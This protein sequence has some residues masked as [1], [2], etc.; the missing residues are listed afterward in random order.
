MMDRHLAFKQ[1]AATEEAIS[2]VSH[3]Y[4]TVS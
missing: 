1:S 4:L 3:V 2:L